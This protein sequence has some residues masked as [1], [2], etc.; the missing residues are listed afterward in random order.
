MPTRSALRRASRNG[1]HPEIVGTVAHHPAQPP[2]ITRLLSPARLHRA[3]AGHFAV[4][5]RNRSVPEPLELGRVATGEVLEKL[6]ARAC[7]VV[8]ERQERV[9]DVFQLGSHE[10]WAADYA[11]STFQ[12]TTNGRAVVAADMQ[13]VG[14][15]SKRSNSWLC[16]WANETNEPHLVSDVARLRTLGLVRGIDLLERDYHEDVDP[17]HCWHLTSIACYLLDYAACYRAPM[18]ERYLFMLLRDV[19]WLG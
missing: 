17:E 9:N 1:H 14:S 11:A 15:F 4:R 16:A 8:S 3:L 7:Q 2:V 19:R 13:L 10:R 12:M 18:D 6:T 5:D